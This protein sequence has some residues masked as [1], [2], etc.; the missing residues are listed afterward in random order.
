MEAWNGRR[1]VPPRT[2]GWREAAELL[3][4]GDYVLAT[5]YE[6]GDAGDHWV[7]GF[8][9]GEME[10]YRDNHGTRYDILDEHGRSQRG[11]GFRRVRGISFEAGDFICR[12]KGWI[13]HSGLSLWHFE[14]NA[15]RLMAADKTGGAK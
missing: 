15:M 12:N 1:N 3:E 2:M 8:F 7:V 4:P 13:R 10:R 5:K 6:D 14:R 11:N 9:G